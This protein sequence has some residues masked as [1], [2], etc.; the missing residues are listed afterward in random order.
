VYGFDQGFNALEAM[1]NGKVVFTGAETEFLNHYNL[2]EDE[3]AIN[4]LPDVDY[5]VDKLSF[6]IENPSEI[7]RIGKNAIKFIKK[8]HHYVNQAKKYVDIWETK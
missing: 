8:E 2:Q 7:S 1:A 5:L 3:V 6:L 4:A